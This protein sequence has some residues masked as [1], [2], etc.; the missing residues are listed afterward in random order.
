MNNDL[1]LYTL[2]DDNNPVPCKDVL[3]WG[4]WFSKN[5]HRRRVAQ[6]DVGTRWVS[7]VFLG[8]DHSHGGLFGEKFP[9]IFETMVF[10]RGSSEDL[11]CERYATWADA[12]AGH[13]RAVHMVLNNPTA[14]TYYE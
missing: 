3:V 12:L 6:T 5:D 4:E 2:D 9:T 10:V 11:Y 1:G 14:V 13:E 7:T 8:L